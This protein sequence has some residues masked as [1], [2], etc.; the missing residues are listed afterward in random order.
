MPNSSATAWGALIDHDA[1][2]GLPG[3]LLEIGLDQLQS[4]L[5]EVMTWFICAHFVVI[6]IDSRRN[7]FID[8]SPVICCDDACARACGRTRARIS[9][10]GCA[11]ARY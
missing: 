1:P 2:K 11:G 9:V 4:S 6:P 8:G 3:T 10:Q 5:Q 7:L